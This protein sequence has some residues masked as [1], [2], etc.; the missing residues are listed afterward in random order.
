[1]H[2]LHLARLY[3]PVVTL[4][5]WAAWVHYFGRSDATVVAWLLL[6]ALSLWIHIQ[7]IQRARD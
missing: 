6:L 1:M 3:A 4:L 5:L 7:E 2:M